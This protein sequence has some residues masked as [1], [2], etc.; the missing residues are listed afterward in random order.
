[1]SVLECIVEV[2]GIMALT[3]LAVT[4]PNLRVVSTQYGQNSVTKY[5]DSILNL[6][7]A[8]AP[9][10]GATTKVLTSDTL[11]QLRC[12]SAGDAPPRGHAPHGIP[13]V[14]RV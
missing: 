14:A 3:K 2:L 4:G 8:H 5:L 1:M 6:K 13:R 11:S 12:V 7:D 10:K 9:G